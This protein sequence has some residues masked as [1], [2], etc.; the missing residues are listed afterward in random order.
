M[1]SMG[2]MRD[3]CLA[4]GDTLH[5]GRYLIQD[6]LGT[7]GFGITY[8]AYDTSLCVEVAIKE[9]FPRRLV[10]RSRAEGCEIAT[11]EL[12]HV[13]S[14][15][16]GKRRFLNE[17]R[18][19]AALQ[20]LR[21]IVLVREHFEENGTAYIAMEYLQGI[22]LMEKLRRDGRMDYKWLLSRF[23]PLI[24]ALGQLHRKN[25]IH[26]DISPDNLMLVGEEERLVL[27]DFGAA[28]D[29]LA[30][31]TVVIFM[32]KGYM[33]LEQAGVDKEGPYTDV[34]AL[35]A[36]FYHCLTGV[37]PQSSIF[38][39]QDDQ[40]QWPSELGVR[41]PEYL[42]TALKKGMAIWSADRFQDM[43][44]LYEAF[45]APPTWWQRC[46]KPLL[47][48][49]LIAGAAAG[50]LLLAGRMKSDR[51]IVE[52]TIESPAKQT[53]YAVG[54]QLNDDG[55]ILNAVRGDGSGQT[56]S[57]NYRAV[58]DF[59]AA[60]L[61]KVEL[62]Y[63]GCS[64]AYYVE[65]V[66]EQEYQNREA[67]DRAQTLLEEGKAWEAACAF[68]ELGDFEDA[69]QRACDLW[70]ALTNRR[71]I[72]AG[73]D[74]SVERS[75]Q[76][77]ALYAAVK[78]DGSV[79]SSRLTQETQTWTD[80]V[81]IAAGINHVVGLRRDGTVQAVAK[82]GWQQR[83]EQFNY[84]DW[85]DIVSVAAG[86]WH[87]VGLRKDGTVAAT[88]NNDNGQC[89]VQE[90]TDV[91]AIAAGY[92]HTF[93]LRRDGTVLVAGEY[94]GDM[95][96][97]SARAAIRCLCSGSFLAAGVTEGGRVFVT[98]IAT[99]TELEQ[100]SRIRFDWGSDWEDVITASC[101]PD[102]VIGIRRDGTAMAAGAYEDMVSGW[103][104]M[105]D[106]S[107]GPDYMLGLRRDGTVLYAGN[108]RQQFSDALWTDIRVACRELP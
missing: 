57:E 17:A 60:G 71:T 102:C 91:V 76:K 56:V 107:I 24:H 46:R 83:D 41:I 9:Y 92:I 98:G 7:G 15:E 45:Q 42:E 59:S 53:V 61:Q 80:I 105:A 86:C 108:G 78:N 84:S 28:R 70:D 94:A 31:K 48:I 12:G 20:G 22:T 82:D 81:A 6:V 11:V 96:D 10:S 87:S 90:W 26:R 54:Q 104:D 5:N 67:Y 51:K 16:A 101:G 35:C 14:F 85:Q 25:V 13:E 32:K 72:T 77:S 18:Q 8:R 79:Q 27:I 69:A 33:P 65:V 52:L 55:L 66:D 29:F 30:D 49:A 95:F 2:Q 103:T 74:S 4:Y 106:V 38:R 37:L 88:G 62:W 93:A 89:D 1:N 75:F 19:L 99:D 23:L 73:C 68:D 40:L 3:E 58:Y 21:S 47:A 100:G 36:T 39:Q 64:T 43:D 63:E 97:F 44:S 50:G 34:Y